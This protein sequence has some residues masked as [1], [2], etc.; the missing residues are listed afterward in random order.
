MMSQL[1]LLAILLVCSAFFSGSETALFALSRHEMNVLGHDRRASHRLVVELMRHPR[2]LLLTLMIGNVTINMFIFATSLSLFQGLVGDRLV[3]ATLLGLLSPIAVTLF[4]EILP[5]GTAIVLRRRMAGRIAPLVRIFQI[6]LSPLS[7]VLQMFL[8]EPLTRLLAGTKRLAPHEH[9]TI[10]ELDQLVA[11]SQ[12]RRIIDAD[13]N[14]MLSG[15]LHLSE[16]KVRDVMVPRVD[17]TTFDVHGDPDE[18][19]HLM[20]ERRFMKLPV[21]DQTIDQIK[22]VIHAKDLFLDTGRSLKSMVRPV[23]FVPEVITLTQVLTHFKRTRTQMA[24]A[25]DEYGGVVG[26][27][28]IEDVAEQIVGELMLPEEAKVPLL[29]RLGKRRY[30]VSGRV[31]IYDWADHFG[32]RPSDEGVT[33]LAGFILARLGRL[34]AVGDQVRIHNVVLTVETLRRRRIESVL[35]ELI[36]DRELPIRSGGGS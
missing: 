4:G 5:K 16:L 21:Y 15:V 12:Q 2:K 28:T 27:V 8:I 26:L 19:R 29:E 36:E 17:I 13:E 33:T 7:F 10:E 9:V 18:L 11:M 24:V 20:R 1:I 14:A 34:P 22:G 35:I 32:I 23:T 3:L 31:S 6:V 30:R 25:V